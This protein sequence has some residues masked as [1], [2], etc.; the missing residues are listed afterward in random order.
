MPRKSEKAKVVGTQY[1]LRIKLTNEDKD[2][3]RDIYSRGLYSQRELAI[4]YKVSKSL[5]SSVVNPERAANIKAYQKANRHKYYNRK[6][7]T[8]YVKE[9]R[10]RKEKLYK[11]GKIQ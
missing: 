2:H 9:Y 1:D 11:E 8:E 4:M 5:I 7:H 10:R 3:I 6:K